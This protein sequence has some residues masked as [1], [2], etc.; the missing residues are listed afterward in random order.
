MSFSVFSVTTDDVE[1]V[2]D[3][4]YWIYSGDRLP[5]SA[6]AAG[7]LAVSDNTIDLGSSAARWRNIHA[8]TTIVNSGTMTAPYLWSLKTSVTLSATA[9]AIEFSGL[10]GDEYEPMLIRFYFPTGTS[11]SD[12]HHIYLNN[13]SATSY[14][15]YQVLWVAGSAGPQVNTFTSMRYGPSA[16][17]SFF[18]FLLYSKTGKERIS[19][20]EGI[21]GST[22]SISIRG[23]DVWYVWN[24]TVN[25]LTSIK[26]ILYDAS[27]SGIINYAPGTRISI[28]G[29]I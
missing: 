10:N 17:P 23:Y 27:D 21:S 18:E 13:D 8:N 5:Y 28:W 11:T 26:F 6:T 2:M 25:T 20:F 22:A 12:Y 1:K 15:H 19:H 4:F 16:W 7:S 3:N 9:S 24:N 14:M 29:A